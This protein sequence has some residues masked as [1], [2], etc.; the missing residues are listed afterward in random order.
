MKQSL[1][2]RLW[3]FFETL[4]ADLEIGLAAALAEKLNIST[5]EVFSEYE[6]WQIAE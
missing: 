6:A 3:S 5:A 2:N 4:D 1:R